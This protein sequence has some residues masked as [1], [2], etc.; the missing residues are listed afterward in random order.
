[1]R[2]PFHSALLSSPSML[3]PPPG[4]LCGL[5]IISQC[6]DWCLRVHHHAFMSH[7][8]SAEHGWHEWYLL[9]C[10]HM[11]CSHYCREHWS[12]KSSWFPQQF[13]VIK[14]LS[15]STEIVSFSNIT[16]N[17]IIITCS[18]HNSFNQWKF[19]ASMCVGPVMLAFTYVSCPLCSHPVF[20]HD[21]WKA[22]DDGGQDPLVLQFV[23]P[24]I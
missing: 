12:S 10:G 8:V 19:N 18:H 1:M 6:V 3:L 14:L 23:H 21:F 16:L 11:Y 17:Q 13:C 5:V 2:L 24:P 4:S 15:T 7:A 20:W 9:T 22:F